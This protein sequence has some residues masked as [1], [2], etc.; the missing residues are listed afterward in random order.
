MPKMYGTEPVWGMNIGEVELGNVHP[1]SA[2]KGSD[3]CIHRP[4]DHHMVDWP[5]NF[6]A[7]RVPPIMERL[8]EH[9][10]GHPDPDDMAYHERSNH[11]DY[12]GVHGC[13]GCCRK[14]KPG[15]AVLA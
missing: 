6:R 10:I 12:L 5:M 4:S 3:C 14:N 7:D 1:E 15:S 8:C 11:G 13:D 9:G 2:C